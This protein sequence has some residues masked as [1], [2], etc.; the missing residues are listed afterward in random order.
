MRIA[1]IVLSTCAALALVGA[2]EAVARPTVSY[3]PSLKVSSQPFI[4][5]GLDGSS[6]HAK[7]SGS[8]SPTLKF[9]ANNEMPIGA[10]FAMTT[11]SGTTLSVL[12]PDLYSR[13]GVIDSGAILHFS[14]R[15]ASGTATATVTFSIV[16]N[17]ALA[18]NLLAGATRASTINGLATALEKGPGATLSF[19]LRREIKDVLTGKE[20]RIIFVKNMSALL[21]KFGANRQDRKWL[22]D[23]FAVDGGN[24]IKLALWAKDVA[25]AFGAYAGLAHGGVGG[26]ETLILSATPVSGGAPVKTPTTATTPAAASSLSG[27]VCRFIPPAL[28]RTLLVTV[29]KPQDKSNPSSPYEKTCVYSKGVDKLADYMVLDGTDVLQ[30]NSA[31]PSQKINHPNPRAYVIYFSGY[32]SSQLKSIQA[33]VPGLGDFAVVTYTHTGNLNLFKAVWAQGSYGYQFSVFS[34]R[35]SKDLG[36]AVARQLSKELPR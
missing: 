10:S 20:S 27:G 31:F 5:A 34:T 12:H 4:V 7:W 13:A 19:E 11:S 36:L 23:N 35:I 3:L 22:L 21:I 18:V 30:L 14:G 15:L 24:V 33:V 28:A 16:S 17:K 6:L 29:T 8:T 9:A 25:Q 32:G 1:A 2:T 26:T